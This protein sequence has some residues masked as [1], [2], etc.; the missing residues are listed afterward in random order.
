MRTEK[1]HFSLST[2]LLAIYLV[3]LPHHHPSLSHSVY[4]SVSFPLSSLFMGGKVAAE[5]KQASE[6]GPLFSAE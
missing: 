4:P 1:T 2:F 5:S 3:V 6:Q